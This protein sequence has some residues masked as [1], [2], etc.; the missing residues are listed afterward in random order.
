MTININSE[1]DKLKTIIG[2]NIRKR[3]KELKYSLDKVNELIDID[4]AHLSRIEN[5]YILINAETL[6]QLSKILM[7]DINFFY[8]DTEIYI[9]GKQEDEIIYIYKNLSAEK[10]NELLTYAKFLLNNK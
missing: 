5:G 7:V 1:S 6:L 3:R 4:K 8:Q 10:Q 9:K 2:K